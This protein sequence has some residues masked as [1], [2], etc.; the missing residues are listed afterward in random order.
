MIVFCHLLRSIL[1]RELIR[2]RAEHRL[3]IVDLLLCLYRLFE[4]F[5]CFNAYTLQL[6]SVRVE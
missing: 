5:L 3:S 2:L 6:E 4:L 1:C